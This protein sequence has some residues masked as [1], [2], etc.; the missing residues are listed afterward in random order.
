MEPTAI[1]PAGRA[2]L[3]GGSRRYDT[4]PIPNGEG[5][6]TFADGSTYVGHFRGGV[7]HGLGRYEGACGDVIEGNFEKGVLE[8]GA[9]PPPKREARHTRPFL[10]P[11][12]PPSPTSPF[13]CPFF[14]GG[15]GQGPGRVEHDDMQ[16]V[17]PFRHGLLHGH[18]LRLFKVPHGL[19]HTHTHTTTG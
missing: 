19:A 11:P 9:Q 12:P 13:I 17:G 3:G 4:V 7:P 18:G 8:V 14:G 6:L 16:E 10:P 5:R 15:A 1:S 2:C